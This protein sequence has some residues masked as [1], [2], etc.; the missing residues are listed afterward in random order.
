MKKLFFIAALLAAC[1]EPPAE[2]WAC[3]TCNPVDPNFAYIATEYCATAFEIFAKTE[4]ECSLSSCHELSTI[5]FN[6]VVAFPAGTVDPCL[7]VAD[8]I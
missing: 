1:G 6:P 5:A 3:Y 8:G 4:F 2:P 7:W